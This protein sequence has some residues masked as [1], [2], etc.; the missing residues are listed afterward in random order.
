MAMKWGHICKPPGIEWGISKEE[1]RTTNIYKYNFKHVI[2]PGWTVYRQPG[3]AH[4]LLYCFVNV[5]MTLHKGHTSSWPLWGI[6]PS[7]SDGPS[8]LTDKMLYFSSSS[9]FINLLSLTSTSPSCHDPNFWL[10]FPAKFPEELPRSSMS[11]PLLPIYI[12]LASLTTALKLFS[13]N[14]WRPSGQT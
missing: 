14:Q 13:F 10:P 7:T 4:L 5:L 3:L 8:P 11:I 9:I 2:D 6:P 12:T 1:G